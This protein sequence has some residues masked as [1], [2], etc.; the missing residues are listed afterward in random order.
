MMYSKTKKEGSYTS[1][2]TLMLATMVVAGMWIHA[3]NALAFDTPNAGA[4]FYDV[5]DKIVHDVLG[6]AVGILIA[7]IVFILGLIMLFNGKMIPMVV[8][9]AIAIILPNVESIVTSLGY[10][11][12]GQTGSTVAH[13]LS[14]F[15]M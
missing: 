1:A 5:Y 12:I 6:G 3:G 9:F 7:A 8:A 2:L 13:S 4:I 10:S 11:P 15:L 14:A